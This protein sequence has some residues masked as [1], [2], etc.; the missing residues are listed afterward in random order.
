VLPAIALNQ[1][2]LNT[3]SGDTS[4]N[5]SPTMAY[6]SDNKSPHLPAYNYRLGGHCLRA[7]MAISARVDYELFP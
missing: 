1:H 2:L 5:S 4:S 3:T 6:R 7:G